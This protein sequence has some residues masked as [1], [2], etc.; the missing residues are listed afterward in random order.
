MDKRIADFAERH[1]TPAQQDIDG[2]FRFLSFSDA[3]SALEKHKAMLTNGWL[4]HTTQDTLNDPHEL[5]FQL[6]W[7]E[8]DDIQGVNGFV[9][10]LKIMLALNGALPIKKGLTVKELIED[11][12]FKSKFEATMTNF[13]SRVR[14]CCF[15][16]NP[17]NPLFWAHYANSHKGYCVKFKTNNN[18]QSIISNTR[19]VYYSNDYPIIQF[20]FLSNLISGLSVIFQKSYEW[21]YEEEY[22]SVFCADWPLQLNNNGTALSLENDEI[23][24]I[25]FGKDMDDESKSKIV[26]LVAAGNFE[27]RFWNTSVSIG[28]YDLEFT[29]YNA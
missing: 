14:V 19:K 25:Y 21:E 15:T 20:P 24:D 5:K 7:P 23:S 4:F 26:S 1:I 27:P 10:D 16:T 13:Y 9:E 28:G 3:R 6:K 12:A 18:P 2:L 22:R 17:K 11:K 8:I 29:K